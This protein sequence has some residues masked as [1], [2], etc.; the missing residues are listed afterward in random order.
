MNALGVYGGTFSPLHNQGLIVARTARKQFSLDKVLFVP[1]GNPPH[2]TGVLDKEFRY[3]MVVA[4]I[5][6]E[7]GMEASRI[8]VDRP[9]ITWSIDTLRELRRIYGADVRL[10]F[11]MGEDNVKTL[12]GYELRQEFCR[13]CKLLIAPRILPDQEVT[14]EWRATRRDEWRKLL[15]EA[16]LDVIELTESG[17]SATEIRAKVRRGESIAHLVPPAVEDLIRRLG[18]YKEVNENGASIA[19]W[20][21]RL[22]DWLLHFSRC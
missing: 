1:N 12:A 19:A 5:A 9:G 10:H 3:D 7:D 20:L 8:E 17:T 22:L 18:H 14:E 11:I 13:L 4:G 16:D 2:K 21:K 15:P 6:G